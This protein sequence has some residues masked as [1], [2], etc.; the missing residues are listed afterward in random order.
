MNRSS[1]V[2]GLAA[3]V[4]VGGLLAAPSRGQGHSVEALDR[5]LGDVEFDR[6]PARDALEW[7]SRTAGFNLVIS[8][9]QLEAEG[10]DP[11]QPITLRLGSGRAE[12]V[13]RFIANEIAGPQ[14][15]VMHIDRH[16]VRLMTREEATAKPVVRVYDIRSML[17]D[18]PD[19][20]DAP[21][22]SLD[23]VLSDN[24]GG[25]DDIFGGLD[26]GGADAEPSGADRAQQIMDVIRSNVE[27]DLWEARGGIGA[28]MTFYNGMLIVRAPE[29]VQQQIGP[30]TPS[31]GPAGLGA[32][33]DTRR[34]AP[35]PAA[36]ADAP[37]RPRASRG[38]A[39]RGSF[40]SGGAT[41]DRRS[42]HRDAYR[43]GSMNRRSNGV[44]G[45]NVGQ[46]YLE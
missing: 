20:D 25:G 42:D 19:F 14:G 13:L 37:G 1:L 46:Y 17:V 30:A 27:P 15:M 43:R 24:E 3:T 28:R 7:L 4:V 31:R 8:W 22:F 33:P 16:Y 34:P 9:R 23:S 12:T 26:G 6:T 11:E 5:M 44:S 38:Y 21:E 18:I 45:I 10:I 39:A 41:R 36:G 2:A 35:R 40:W 32:R 29:Y